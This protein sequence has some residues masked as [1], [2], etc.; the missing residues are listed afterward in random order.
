MFFTDHF[1]TDEEKTETAGK[2]YLIEQRRIKQMEH[3]RLS[4]LDE[5]ELK[6]FKK[7]KKLQ[8]LQELQKPLQEQHHQQYF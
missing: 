3:E 7:F 8:E 5:V 1:F 4:H 2:A 6:R